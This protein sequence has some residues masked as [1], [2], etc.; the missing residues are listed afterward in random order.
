[1]SGLVW[2]FGITLLAIFKD[3][4]QICA[5]MAAVGRPA[6]I[7]FDMIGFDLRSLAAL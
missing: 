4:S 5:F 2:G 6:L 3:L 1:M 7:L